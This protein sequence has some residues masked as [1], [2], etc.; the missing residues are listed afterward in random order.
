MQLDAPSLNLISVSPCDKGHSANNEIPQFTPSHSRSF[1]E[2][3]SRFPVF[4]F[5]PSVSL[6]LCGE[7]PLRSPN[8]FQAPLGSVSSCS[9]SFPHLCKILFSPSFL[10]FMHSLSI[11]PS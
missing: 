10:A 1:A 8:L 6:Y 5:V 9:N 4:R 3:A 7:Y 2:F 11:F